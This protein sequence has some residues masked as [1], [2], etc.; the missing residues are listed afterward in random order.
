MQSAFC[1]VGV[2]QSAYWFMGLFT[3][4]FWSSARRKCHS[5]S[6]HHSVWKNLYRVPGVADF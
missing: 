2:L 4:G 1:L 6:Y 3:L 5:V